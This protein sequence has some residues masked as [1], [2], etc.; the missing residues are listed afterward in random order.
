MRFHH[1]LTEDQSRPSRAYISALT[2]TCGYF[3]GGFIPLLPYFF[4]GDIE[5]ALAFSVLVMAIAL[6]VF[7]Y[8]KTLLVGERSR[9]VCVQGGLQMVVLGGLAAGAAMGIVKALG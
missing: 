3:F 8:G 6:F 1:G 7:G 5:T 9:W 2:I 4:A